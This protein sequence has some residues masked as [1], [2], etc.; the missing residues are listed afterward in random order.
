MRETEVIERV[1]AMASAGPRHRELIRGIGDDCAI[2][3]PESGWDLVFTTDF[4]LE[5]R[6]FTLETHGAEDVGYKA[7]ARSLSDLAAMG[8]EPVFCL[9]SLAVPN[10]L[11]DQWTR[12]FYEGLLTL[13]SAYQVMLAGGDLARF[14]HVI[15]DVICCGRV[16]ENQALTRDRAKAGDRIFVT[17]TLGESAAGLRTGQG[18]AWKR[19]LRPSPRVEAGQA[20]RNMG[21]VAAMDLSDGLALDL[22]RMC[23]E[24]NVSAELM[25]SLPIARGATLED[26][27]YGGEDYEL[28][29]AAS[30]QMKLPRAI[31][32]VPITEIGTFAYRTDVPVSFRGEPLEAAGFDHFA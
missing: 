31:A 26:A 18:K 12:R 11:A 22:R 25:D 8:S 28:L 32:N 21:V 6:H 7:L 9:V 27:L 5:G 23:D 10:K 2:F 16:P 30:E 20:L 14:D 17:G 29:F 1:R 19:H 13:A 24:S 4:V 3:R 15:A